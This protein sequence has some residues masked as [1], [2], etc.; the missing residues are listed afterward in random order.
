VKYHYVRVAQERRTIKV[1]KVHT[2][3]NYS[4]IMTKATGTGTFSRHVSNLMTGAAVEPTAAAA[5]TAAVAAATKF[6]AKTAAAARKSSRSIL[7]ARRRI[8]QARK[9]PEAGA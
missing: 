3:D 1:E 8:G 2:D 5:A 4:D 9:R 6:A 7:P